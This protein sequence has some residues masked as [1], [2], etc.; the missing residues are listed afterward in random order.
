MK[1]RNLSLSL[2]FPVVLVVPFYSKQI[3]SYFG[4][5][6]VPY[7]WYLTLVVIA[8]I[9]T[10][11]NGTLAYFMIMCGYEKPYS[12]QIFYVCILTFGAGYCLIDLNPLIVSILCFISIQLWPLFFSSR[13]INR[14]LN[15]NYWKFES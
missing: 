6:Y 14:N 12:K 15:V 9:F 11:L 8:Q 2:I 1:S 7:G 3:L 4:T 13:F 5:E 10:L